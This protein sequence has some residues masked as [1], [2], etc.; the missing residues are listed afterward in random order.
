MRLLVNNFVNIDIGFNP[1]TRTGCDSIRPCLTLFSVW[2]QSTHPHGVRHYAVSCM[3][4]HSIV[5]IH[6]P[7]RGATVE[8]R[9]EPKGG[10]FQSTHPHGVRLRKAA[11]SRTDAEFQSTHPHGVRPQGSGQPHRCGV[12]IHAPARGATPLLRLSVFREM[13]QST[14][15]HGV[16]HYYCHR[17]MRLSLF[18]STHP[19][20]VRLTMIGSIIGG[21]M[22]Q[23]THPHGVRRG[24]GKLRGRYGCFNPRT[25]T[26]CDRFHKRMRVMTVVSIHAP[27]RGATYRCGSIAPN[28][29]FQSTHPHGV[30]PDTP[31]PEL[32]AQLVSIHAPARGAT[33][34]KQPY[35]LTTTFQSTHPH[36]VRLNNAP[37]F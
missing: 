19:H 5:S 27:A 32:T 31:T 13:F 3:K 30:R 25:R 34:R 15:P 26:G 1:R 10:E 8:E 2:F 18:Q 23:S 28:N 9:K 36:G 17:A 14:H 12:S 22:F 16:R 33:R 21:A 6:A 29:R 37:F 20:G 24:V 35:R 4:Q 11:D 7:A